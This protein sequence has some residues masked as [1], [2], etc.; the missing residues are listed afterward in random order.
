MSKGRVEAVDTRELV[1][2]RLLEAP[3]DVVFD[4]WTDPNHLLKWWGP[5]DFTPSELEFD[6]RPGGSY[7]A[8]ITASEGWSMWM[9]GIYKE[10]SKPSRLV[11]TF[12]W[13]EDSGERGY[14]TL[15]TVTFEEAN[16]KT[17]FTFRQGIFATVESCDSHRGGWNECFDRLEN[18]IASW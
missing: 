11:F 5:K 13:D 16:G 3:P 2:T 12:A 9:S 6:V 17:T 14:E 8:C 18:F 1:I 4:L 7:R 15:I 10:V